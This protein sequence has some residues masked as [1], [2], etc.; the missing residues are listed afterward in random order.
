MYLQM[1]LMPRELWVHPLN[2]LWEEKGEFYTLYPDLRHFPNQFFQM[3][4]MS[5]GKFDKL[6][7][8]L[9]PEVLK[10]EINFRKT[11]SPE[12]QLVLTLR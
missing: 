3:Y 5:V 12:Q 8:E 1:Q 4:R 6:L 11:I 9:S 7:S 10:K 2:E